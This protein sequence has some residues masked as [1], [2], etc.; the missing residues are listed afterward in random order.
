MLKRQTRLTFARCGIVDPL[1]LDDYSAHGGYKGLEKAL[2]LGRQAIV[3]EVVAIR[4]ARPRRRRLPDRHQ[5][6]APSPNAGADRNTSSA[7]PTKATA[8]P[9]PTA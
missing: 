5:V 8:A 6:A 4:P 1:S 9:S 7:T 3:E 2:A